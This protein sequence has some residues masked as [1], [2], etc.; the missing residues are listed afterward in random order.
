MCLRLYNSTDSSNQVLTIVIVQNHLFRVLGF[1]FFVGILTVFKQG[2]GCTI[3]HA[4]FI[5][6]FQT[7]ADL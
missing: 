7:L 3:Q 1:E 2:G 4:V 6:T 5:L